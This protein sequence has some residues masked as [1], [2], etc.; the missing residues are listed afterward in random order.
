M[1]VVKMSY[2]LDRIRADFPILE[3]ETR[4]GVRLVYLDST[5]TS[6]KP[7]SVIEA[8]DA[9][10]RTSN[11]N[12]HRGVHTLAEEATALYEH[13]RGHVAR[14]INAA[15]SQEVVFTRNT[16]EA[17]NLVARTWAWSALKPGDLIVLTEM[18][19]HSNLVP[20]QMVAAEK[21]LTL[22]FVPMT[23]D[24]TLDLEAY[25]D[26][27]SRSPRLVA[28]TQMSNVLGTITPAHQMVQMAHE[29]GAL[30]L[31]DGA[32]SVPHLGVDVQALDTDFLAFSAH[33]MCGPTGI[34]V[35]Y[36]KSNLLESMPPFLGGGDMIREVKLRSF[37]PNT[38]P[39]KFEAGTPA[40]AEAIGFE[41]AV[42]Y[43]E[44]LGMKS[45]ADHEHAIVEYAM[46]RLEEVPGL[47]VLG[48]APEKRGGVV[49][50]TFDGIHPHDVAQILDRSGIAVR[51]GHHCAQPLHE[52]L[53]IPA[54][55]RASFYLYSSPEEV[56]KLVEGLYE[57]KKVFA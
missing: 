35:L 38:L 40:I 55:T 33:K 37:R 10:Y 44:Q 50:F 43:L 39:H 17:I 2:D 53:G 23:E 22:E 26:L 21:G 16:T 3:R 9:F 28:F 12:I 25:G 47:R 29:V 7:A 4:P 1:P 30:T 15:A 14:F 32:Q 51:A 36:G 56:D 24:G 27:L 31:I 49:S 8:M 57:V 48:P 11:A 34:G 45:I 6:Q 46:E 41:A 19:H 13:S 20:W 54:S 42:Q 5:A 52:R 18:E